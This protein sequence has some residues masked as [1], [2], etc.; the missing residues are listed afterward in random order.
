MAAAKTIMSD[1]VAGF[2]SRHAIAGAL[3]AKAF[4]VPAEGFAPSDMGAPRTPRHFSPAD[5]DGNPTAGWDPFD[6]TVSQPF[7]DP[8]GAARAAG[9][10]E[11]LAAAGAGDARDHDLAAALGRAF[12]ARIDRDAVAR[13]LRQT[14]L[15]LV[16]R[17]VGDTGIAPDVLAGRIERAVD[18]LADAAESALLRVHPDDVA[19]LDGRLPK[20]VFA[21]GDAAVARG[22][23][24]LESASTI[25]EDGPD[26]WLDQLSQAIDRVAVPPE[27]AAC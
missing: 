6:A 9:Y 19:L 3:L 14:V 7:V 27:P 2:S 13:Q 4:G 10:A 8:V 26:A 18:M 16:A 11:G 1:F 20:S 21:V 5:P 24:V 17:I 22:G 25:V 23:F 12:A 15:A